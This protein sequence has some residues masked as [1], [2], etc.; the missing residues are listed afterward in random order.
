MGR[1]KP[2]G[3]EVPQFFFGAIHESSD[4][5]VLDLKV[6]AR[7]KKQASTQ[8]AVL[9]RRAAAQVPQ[10]MK[11]RLDTMLSADPEVDMVAD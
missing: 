6:V 8:S 4:A 9:F 11:Q 1:G 7:F 2:A 5:G 10:V 3:Q